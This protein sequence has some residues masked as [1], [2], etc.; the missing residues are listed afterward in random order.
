MFEKLRTTFGLLLCVLLLAACGSTDQVTADEALTQAAVSH[1]LRA[2]VQKDFP[3]EI[4]GDD[5]VLLPSSNFKLTHWR[6]F[7]ETNERAWLAVAKRAGTD[8]ASR[9]TR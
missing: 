6:A 9:P 5:V 1:R 4:N 3:D 2:D 7:L 8:V